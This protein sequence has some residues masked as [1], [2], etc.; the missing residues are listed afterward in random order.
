MAKLLND[1]F[2]RDYLEYYYDKQH[3][4]KVNESSIPIY[5]YD[6]DS[7]EEDYSKEFE[8]SKIKPPVLNSKSSK[9]ARQLFSESDE[10][11]DVSS[12]MSH[13]QSSTSMPVP[14]LTS[15]P[16]KTKPALSSE[17]GVDDKACVKPSSPQ[18][19][20]CIDCPVNTVL[21]SNDLSICCA[22]SKASRKQL[23]NLNLPN[24]QY[25]SN[26][27]I[28]VSANSLSA[29]D[30]LGISIR[31]SRSS[32][33]YCDKLLSE[34]RSNGNIAKLVQFGCIGTFRVE[35][36]WLLRKY[37]DI[38]DIRRHVIG[39]STWLNQKDGFSMK[40][41][42]T[43]ACALW[44]N[45]PYKVILKMSNGRNTRAIDVTS[46]TCLCEERY[47][48]NMVVDVSLFKYMLESNASSNV[49]SLVLPTAIW[50]WKGCQK[51][52]LEDEIT[53]AVLNCHSEIANINQIL[54][55]VFMPSHWGIV[56]IDL[57]DAKAYFD[58]GMK[59][60]VPHG[61]LD[62]VKQLLDVLHKL[63]PHCQ[64][65]S[66]ERWNITSFDRLGM[67][68]QEAKEAKLSGQGSGSC[69]IGVI[70]AA[71][72]LMSR[73]SRAVRAFSWTFAQSRYYRKQL[74]LQILKWSY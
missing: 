4:L 37:C 74:M 8:K 36:L 31:P 41:L 38:E 7:W 48:D 45:D 14:F 58:D 68:S 42:E 60:S 43:L 26:S 61:T 29:L 20:S 22:N 35:D 65:F 23:A 67:P 30:P 27:D 57:K 55:P 62:T 25:V 66:K 34:A 50:D 47:I 3:G 72:D 59:F 39:E 69:A 49:K 9:K 56:Y 53:T 10:S 63:Y 73:G 5:Q 28:K 44:D 52:Y 24:I 21:T 19:V 40:E 15:T 33:C 54:I 51:G 13:L 71:K 11:T 2:G 6:H 17:T 46:L 70:M 16:L 1:I 32:L 18:I 12:Y 64:T